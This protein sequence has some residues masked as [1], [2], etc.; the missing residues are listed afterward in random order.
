[1]F[2]SLKS[3]SALVAACAAVLVGASAATAADLAAHRAAYTV[4]Q[5]A[6]RASETVTAI[7]GQIAYGVER[8]CDGWLMAQSGTMNMHLSSGEVVP[9]TLHFSSWE[10]L[11]GARYRFTVKAEGSSD[12]VILGTAQ[13]SPAIEG[14]AVFARPE[15]AEFTLPPGTLFPVAHTFFMIETAQ[16]GKTQA[17]SF[18]FEGTEVEGAKLLVVF[19][20]PLSANAKAIIK[21]VGGELLNRPGW[22]FRLAYF[23]PADQ[24]GEPL[25]EVEVDLLDNGVAPRWLLDYGSYVVEMKLNKI[26]ALQRPG[27]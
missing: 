25:Y 5:D 23:D 27:C 16:A 4:S 19:A 13:A 24:G 26:E 11:D 7:S 3:A 18:I 22:N 20:S 9:Q 2:P 6:S 12:E 17:Q 1:M 21:D 14:R 10:S 15:A 8:V